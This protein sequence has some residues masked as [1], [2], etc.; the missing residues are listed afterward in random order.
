M[1]DKSAGPKCTTKCKNLYFGTPRA[2]TA[3]VTDQWVG[4]CSPTFPAT[5]VSVLVPA[6]AP[7]SG[8]APGPAQPSWPGLA[9]DPQA[10][11]LVVSCSRPGLRSTPALIF[12]V[13][14]LQTLPRE[15]GP[16]PPEK[17]M[18]RQVCHTAVRQMPPSCLPSLWGAQGPQRG[19]LHISQDSILQEAGPLC[20]LFPDSGDLC[21]FQPKLLAERGVLAFPVQ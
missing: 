18:D 15:P 11:P 3:P 17:R 4:R 19:P 14:S 7:R 6:A 8:K 1:R 10:K 20:F 13:T 21:L 12:R 9:L 5:T 2:Y 16:L